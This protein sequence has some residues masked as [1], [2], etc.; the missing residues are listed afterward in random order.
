M[1]SGNDIIYFNI[2]R[3]DESVRARSL[4]RAVKTYVG[5]KNMNHENNGN[6]TDII[7]NGVSDNEEEVT[8]EDESQ[9]I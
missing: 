7:Q 9:I 2:T 3:D 4:F 5:E 1:K 8:T 6:I